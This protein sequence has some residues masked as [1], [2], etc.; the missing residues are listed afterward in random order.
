MQ[1]NQQVRYSQLVRPAKRLF[2][3]IKWTEKDEETDN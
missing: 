3:L 2:L 1:D